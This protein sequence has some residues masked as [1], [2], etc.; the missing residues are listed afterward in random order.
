MSNIR[1]K[2]STNQR[3]NRFSC[4]YIVSIPASSITSSFT[5]SLITPKHDMQQHPYWKKGIH[6]QRCKVLHRSYYSNAFSSALREKNC[7]TNV[8]SL[9]SK[10]Y[11]PK[12]IPKTLGLTWL[13]Q[14]I[15]SL[16]WSARPLTEVS[17]LHE[18]QHH[19]N[20][21]HDDDDDNKYL[22][23]KNKTTVTVFQVLNG[24]VFSFPHKFLTFFDHLVSEIPLGYYQVA[25][26]LLVGGSNMFQPLW[27]NNK[28]GI[29]P[30]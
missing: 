7:V 16:Y 24:L 22:S 23:P 10:L 11:H 19:N 20:N 18:N 29:F 5:E 3:L 28:M 25:H 9:V 17:Y 26:D 1:Q 30:K 12:T 21:H 27:K 6:T 2:T 14:H 13:R 8:F 15:K 4:C